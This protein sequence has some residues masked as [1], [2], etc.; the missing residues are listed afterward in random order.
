[1]AAE[2]C[3]F[4]KNLLSFKDIRRN[5]YHIETINDQNIEYLHITRV[6]SG[7]KHVLEKLPA[8]FSGLYYTSINMVETH[9]VVN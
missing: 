6:I 1:M 5:G 3:K 2:S 9:A 4:R 8:F 7:K